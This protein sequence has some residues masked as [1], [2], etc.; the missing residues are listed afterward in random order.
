MSFIADVLAGERPNRGVITN[1]GPET[2][3]DV[4][5]L[6]EVYIFLRRGWMETLGWPEERS[7][8]GLFWIARFFQIHWHPLD[9]LGAQILSSVELPE[10]YSYLDQ[11][12]SITEVI[13]Q[14]VATDAS[15]AWRISDFD[16]DRVAESIDW[17]GLRNTLSQI[18]SSYQMPAKQIGADIPPLD[19]RA[20]LDSLIDALS[21]GRPESARKLAAL[22]EN[23]R[24]RG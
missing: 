11:M 24:S 4:D 22:R 23:A 14:H 12:L 2:Q 8:T 19:R 1:L 15:S 16:G 17:A 3:D 21:G 10:E 7:R 18:Y 9:E 5:I 6:Y 13:R 20:F